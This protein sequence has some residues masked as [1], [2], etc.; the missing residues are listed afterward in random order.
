M[1]WLL[2]VSFGN[3]IKQAAHYAIPLYLD[4]VPSKSQ[5]PRLIIGRIAEEVASALRLKACP[6]D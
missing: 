1:V 2:L 5:N 4:S 3:T 6:T